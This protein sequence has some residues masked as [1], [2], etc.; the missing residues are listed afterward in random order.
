MTTADDSDL[1]QWTPGGTEVRGLRGVA[2][3]MMAVAHHLLSLRWLTAPR[4]KNK[5]EARNELRRIVSAHEGRPYAF[6]VEHVAQTKRLEF[7]SSTATSYQATIE[8]VWDAEPGGAVRVLVAL[9]D[10]GMGA[11]YPLTDSLLIQKPHGE[12]GRRAEKHGVEQSVEPDERR[13]P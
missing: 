12:P 9:D 2:L 13:I 10:G 5:E 4:W 1:D 3:A 8:A 6:W 11:Y 7:R